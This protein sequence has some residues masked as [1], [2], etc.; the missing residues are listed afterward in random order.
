MADF[1]TSSLLYLGP[2]TL[3]ALA[4]LAFFTRCV[5]VCACVESTDQWTMTIPL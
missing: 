3:H 5:R 4:A 2:L 1:D